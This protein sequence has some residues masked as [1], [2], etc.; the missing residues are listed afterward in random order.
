MTRSAA[1]PALTES[2]NPSPP[3][4]GSRFGALPMMMSPVADSVITP[5]AAGVDD[6][7]AR[8]A[9]A[10]GGSCQLGVPGDGARLASA[11]PPRPIPINAAST[12]VTVRTGRPNRPGR[13]AGG[14]R[15]IDGDDTVGAQPGTSPRSADQGVGTASGWRT[16]RLI[17]RRLCARSEVRRW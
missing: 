11:T 15:F 5:D 1:S 2:K 4:A 12:I 17:E 7:G 10:A 9:A 8:P 13:D 14:G 6:L 3:F 16:P